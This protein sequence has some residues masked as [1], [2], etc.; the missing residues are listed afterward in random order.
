MTNSLLMTALSLCRL[1]EIQLD[2]YYEAVFGASYGMV[3]SVA[4]YWN[5]PGGFDQVAELLAGHPLRGGCAGVVVDFLFYYCSVE[6]VGAEAQGDLGDLGGEHLPVGLDVR[7]VIQQQTAYG[8]LANVGKAGGD[9]QVVERCVFRMEGKWDEG[10]EAAGFVLHFTQFE[11][12]IDAVFVVLDMAVKH[13]G[14]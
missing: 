11:H 9:G 4:L 1:G 7:E 6:I 3:E 13:R 5:S 12:V 8:Y 2:G 10:L 14:I